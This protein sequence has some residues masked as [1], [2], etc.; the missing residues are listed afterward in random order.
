[1]KDPFPAPHPSLL[2]DWAGWSFNAGCF[3]PGAVR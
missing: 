1:M 3:G 2:G